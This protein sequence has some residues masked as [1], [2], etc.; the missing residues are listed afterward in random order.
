MG[1]INKFS[2]IFLF[3][4][5]ASGTL[6][7]GSYFARLTVTYNLFKDNQFQL[8]NYINAHNLPGIL[9]IINVLVIL[10]SVLYIIFIISFIIFL[11]SSKI[12]LK[13]NG[14][15]FI[16]TCIIFITFPLELYLMSIDYKSIM[17]VS[18]SN[19]NVNAVLDLYIKRFKVLSSFPIIEIICYLAI[20]FFVLFRPFKLKLKE[21]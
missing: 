11:I 18:M 6:W 5:V 19:F 3:I 2:K 16:V 21:R 9:T 10:T 1:N 7:F 14:W 20:I 4:C 17:L 13:Q 15:L 12:S 8:D